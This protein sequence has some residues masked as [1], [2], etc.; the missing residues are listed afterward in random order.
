MGAFLWL[1]IR[2]KGDFKWATIFI[3]VSLEFNGGVF[4]TYKHLKCTELTKNI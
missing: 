4:I 3:F 1:L 2:K